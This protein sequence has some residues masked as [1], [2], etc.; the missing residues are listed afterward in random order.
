[1]AIDQTVTVEKSQTLISA[2]TGNTRVVLI[3]GAAYRLIDAL[4]QACSLHLARRKRLRE[5]R[6][7]SA[8]TNIELRDIAIS[9]EEIRAAM[10]SKAKY[11]LRSR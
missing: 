2:L 7:L 11:L 1:M 10:R 8:M 9:R 3:G 6:E 4:Q 5:L